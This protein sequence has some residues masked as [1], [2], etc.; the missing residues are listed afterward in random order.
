MRKKF[1]F[2]N[3]C[4]RHNF[5]LLNADLFTTNRKLTIIDQIRMHQTLNDH[6]SLNNGQIFTIQ[7]SAHSGKFSLSNPEDNF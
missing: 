7:S 5:Q 6:I 1:S 3:K 2:Q 4:S